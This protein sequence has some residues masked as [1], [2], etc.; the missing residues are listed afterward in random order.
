MLSPDPR[1]QRHIENPQQ[2]FHLCPHSHHKPESHLFMLPNGLKFEQHRKL[3]R[4]QK[5]LLKKR[6]LQPLPKPQPHI[7]LCHHIPLGQIRLRITGN[8][9]PDFFNQAFFGSTSSPLACRNPRINAA[10]SSS[11][12][13]S[14]SSATASTTQA[15]MHFSLS[16][17]SHRSKALCPLG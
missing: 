6:N 13:I 17:S 3:P 14:C 5:I 7:Q 8:L 2:C 4:S 12:K 11:V 9:T 10:T 15:A 1:Q 16:P